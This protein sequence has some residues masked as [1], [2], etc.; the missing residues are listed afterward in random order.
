MS[1]VPR[2]QTTRPR[3]RAAHPVLGKRRLNELVEE[4]IIDAYG[5]SEQ[6]VGLLTML[7]EHL[8]VPFTTEILGAAVRVER[9]DLNDADE[10][11]AICRRDQQRQRIPILDLPR[12]SPPPRGWEWIEAYCHWARGGR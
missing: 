5:E 2:R 7:E 12:P 1:H 11:V 3:T 10:I 8:A 9:V 4:A 6:R